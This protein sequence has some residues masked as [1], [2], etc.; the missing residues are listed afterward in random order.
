MGRP[1][2]PC[3]PSGSHSAGLF[4]ATLGRPGALRSFRVSPAV[5]TTTAPSATLVPSSSCCHEVYPS[6]S[7]GHSPSGSQPRGFLPCH[8]REDRGHPEVT[9]EAR[10][11]RADLTHLLA[12]RH[13]RL[14]PVRTGSSFREEAGCRFVF[15]RPTSL[16]VRPF[17][18][19]V[20]PDTLPSATTYRVAWVVAGLHGC[21]AHSDGKKG[22]VDTSLSQPPTNGVPPTASAQA[23]VR[24]MGQLSDPHAADTPSS[25][26]RGRWRHISGPTPGHGPDPPEPRAGDSEHDRR[27]AEGVSA[28][29]RELAGNSA[30]YGEQ[31]LRDRLVSMAY[32]PAEIDSVLG[33]LY[34]EGSVVRGSDWVRLKEAEP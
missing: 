25:D 10:Y 4:R 27:I 14:P 17:R 34:G 32:S 9:M 19:G 33:R 2:I 18:F 22:D 3:P 6:R 12:V 11:P 1:T 31:T 29:Q 7:S 13:T 15:L 24:A 20:S 23:G 26:E 5:T 16:R 21:S 8:G 28:L 30:G